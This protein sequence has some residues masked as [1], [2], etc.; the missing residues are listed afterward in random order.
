MD[1]KLYGALRVLKGAL[2]SMRARKS[3]T[4]VTMSSVFGFVACPGAMAY[5]C[6]NFALDGLGESLAADLAP[7]NIRSVI[8]LPGLFRT[9]VMASAHRPDA[10][11][12]E[13]YAESIGGADK[14]VQYSAAN[15]EETQ[16]G[17][18][19][20]LGKRL[21]EFVDGTGMA[22]GMEK[23]LRLSL[24]NDG[25]QQTMGKMASLKENY[26]AVGAIAGSTDFEGAAGKGVNFT[27]DIGVR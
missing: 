1:T 13:A 9:N 19:S 16:P 17:D 2:P 11:I 26:E 25:Y 5:N 15:P 14:Y 27:E 7:F 23:Y 20:K 18:P 10:G 6:V 4:V 3:G 8:L 22:K 24:G 12:S 21:V